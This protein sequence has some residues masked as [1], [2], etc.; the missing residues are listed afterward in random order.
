MVCVQRVKQECISNIDDL[1]EPIAPSG[2][3]VKSWRSGLV[4]LKLYPQADMLWREWTHAVVGLEWFLEQYEA[5]DA[6]FTVNVEGKGL[7]VA[8][9]K[10]V[11]RARNST[12]AADVA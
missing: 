10:F 11:T 1:N 3:A 5:V 8:S 4:I 2:V 6:A 9:G 7:T 12:F